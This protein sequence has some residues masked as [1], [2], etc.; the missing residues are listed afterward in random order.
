M[1][2]ENFSEIRR[3]IRH[4]VGKTVRY[5]KSTNG[6]QTF[7]AS[8]AVDRLVVI[9]AR[10]TETF[11]DAGGT[12]TTFKIG[13]TGTDDKFAAAA[14]F[15]AAEKGTVFVLTGTLS[16]SAALIVTANDAATTGTG[17]IKVTVSV[18]PVSYQLRP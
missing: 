13:Q 16:S 7:L 17:A 14:V 9:T 11:A 18:L 2:V 8:A 6:V 1:R 15:T 10:V 4:A 12:Q 5:F 3:L